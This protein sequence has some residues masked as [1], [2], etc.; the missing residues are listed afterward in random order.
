MSEQLCLFKN[1]EYKTD[2]IKIIEKENSKKIKKE[3]KS[4]L[5]EE[6]ICFIKANDFRV[7]KKFKPLLSKE[8]RSKAVVQLHP[9]QRIPFGYSWCPYCA[10]VVMLVKD[11]YLGVKRC[12]LCGI[13]DRDNYMK[14]ANGINK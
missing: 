7:Q 9:P 2:R 13:S 14:I 8:E 4:K 12:P 11:S 1:N 5:L 6:Q 10:K 3:N